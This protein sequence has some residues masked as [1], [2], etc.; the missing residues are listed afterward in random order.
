VVFRVERTGPLAL[1]HRNENAL[2]DEVV[3]L[4]VA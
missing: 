4:E 2:R 1:C 3:L